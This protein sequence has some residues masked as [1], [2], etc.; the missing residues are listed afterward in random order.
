MDDGAPAYGDGVCYDRRLFDGSEIVWGYF[1]QNALV[2]TSWFAA[3]W[4]MSWY[5]LFVS[6]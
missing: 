6:F 4:K 5:S 3:M 1:A 2:L